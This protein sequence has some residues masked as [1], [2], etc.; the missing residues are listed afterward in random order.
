MGKKKNKKVDK[1]SRIV[2]ESYV[3]YSKKFGIPISDLI[4]MVE[5]RM[6]ID[7]RIIDSW[8]ITIYDRV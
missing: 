4:A 1:D 2:D 6:P 5:G 3:E 7:Q 8:D